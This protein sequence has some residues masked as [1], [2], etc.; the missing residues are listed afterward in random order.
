MEK[1]IK[2]LNILNQILIYNYS[3]RNKKYSI[4]ISLLLISLVLLVSCSSD[5]NE[6]E[7]KE[8]IQ[9]EVLLNTD[10][11]VYQI[12]GE[13]FSKIFQET[14]NSVVYIKTDSQMRSGSGS[15]FVWDDSGLII[16]NFHVINNAEKI[17][18][19]FFNGMEYEA[20][21]IGSDPPS[22]IAL[23]KIEDL[24][25][26]IEPL[27]FGKSYQVIPGETAIALGNPFGEQFTIT[28]G[29]ISGVGRT[30][31]SGFSTYSIPAVLQ[32]DAA[33]NPG[34]SGGPLLNISGDVIGM[35]TQIISESGSFSGVGFAVPS[36]LIEKVVVAI[37]NNGKH[38]YPLLG[39]SGSDLNMDIREGTGV[40]RSITGAYV[41][42]VVIGGPSDEAGLL[43]DTGNYNNESWDGDIITS[44]NGEKI[45]SMDDLVGYLALYTYPEEKIKLGIIR[46]TKNITLDV[47]LGTR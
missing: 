15:G 14:I 20:T 25:H 24:E 9:E 29:I 39:I 45:K 5:E 11:S 37:V 42:D 32:T 10:D 18:I 34:N 47:V 4:L 44:V 38:E 8:I 46:D 33:I 43:Y 1:F 36:D 21:V 35:N 19:K 2:F 28:T 17:I 27:N 41:T 6:L 23:L 13:N 30:K 16:T 26:T 3:M 31:L 22:D 12:S 7:S 40:D